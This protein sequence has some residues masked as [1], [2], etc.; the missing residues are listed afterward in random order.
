MALLTCAA[1]AI[2]V[3]PG[4]LSSRLS[5]AL[6]QELGP[7]QLTKTSSAAGVCV[8][9]DMSQSYLHLR[10]FQR[11]RTILQRQIG[12]VDGDFDAALRVAVVLTARS[13]EARALQ[14]SDHRSRRTPEPTQTSTR[15][16]L[17][18]PSSAPRSESTALRRGLSVPGGLRFPAGLRPQ[19]DPRSAAG[20]P[21]AP[22]GARA[23]TTP[24]PPAITEAKPGG[25]PRAPPDRGDD[26]GSKPSDEPPRAIRGTGHASAPPA[27]VGPGAPR[28]SAGPP[29]ISPVTFDVGL[30]FESSLWVAPGTP[31]LGP[32]LELRAARG[33]WTL[34]LRAS[35]DG[36]FCC[37]SKG[38]VHLRA[39]GTKLMAQTG[40]RVLGSDRWTGHV[41]VGGG[42]RWLRGDARSTV[43]AA[44]GTLESVTLVQGVLQAG[45]RVEVRVPSHVLLTASAHIA[46]VAG[47]DEIRLPAAIEGQP[48]RTGRWAPGLSVGAHYQLPWGL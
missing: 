10:V 42:V 6:V 29:R 9:L 46:A 20:A 30:H 47:P 48:F 19:P 27:A 31:R 18:S 26:P 28:I 38:D 11:D 2:H 1:P 25:T 34:S 12:V 13:V 45:L 35:V 4:P 37:A 33:P 5:A 15:T 24:T 43:F 7:G 23:A 44:T 16:Q 39:L 40:L 36:L 22:P 41:L 17:S 21:G 8:D 32:A 3:S 14:G